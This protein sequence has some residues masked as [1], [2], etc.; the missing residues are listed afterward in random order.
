MSSTSYMHDQ[1]T[2]NRH[3]TPTIP[4]DNLAEAG[5]YVCTWSGHLLRVPPDGI[6]RGRSPLMS[7]VAR[8]PLYVTKLCGDPYLPLAKARLLAADADLNVNF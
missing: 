5:C 6:A 3:R 4:F 8:K 2:S 7:F 1:G